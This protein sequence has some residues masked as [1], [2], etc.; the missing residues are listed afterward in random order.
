MEDAAS[1][2]SANGLSAP[3]GS[4]KRW[5]E[6]PFRTKDYLEFLAHYNAELRRAD[7]GPVMVVRRTTGAELP[8]EQ[9]GKLQMVKLLLEEFGTVD[10]VNKAIG[11]QERTHALDL[12]R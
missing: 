9:K 10:G 2:R 4:F 5:K 11:N 6:K 12:S 1:T 8:L 7:G 3:R